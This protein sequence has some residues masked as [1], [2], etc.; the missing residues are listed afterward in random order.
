MPPM[1]LI[2]SLPE[3]P[4]KVS[5]DVVPLSVRFCTVTAMLNTSWI[6]RPPWSVAVTRTLRLS[7]A[8]M[9]TVPV[10]LR[11]L[12]LKVSHDG[13]AIPSESVAV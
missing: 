5:A 4:V 8:P 1:P 11:V 13:S 6:A 2:V 12:A 10:N 9:G 3:R 7:K